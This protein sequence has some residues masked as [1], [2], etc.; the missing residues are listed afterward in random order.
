MSGL[1]RDGL[2]QGGVRGLRRAVVAAETEEILDGRCACAE[3]PVAVPE[4]GNDHGRTLCQTNRVGGHL[5]LECL[6]HMVRTGRG[7]HLVVTS[8]G[9][10]TGTIGGGTVFGDPDLLAGVAVCSED[11]LET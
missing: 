7:G 5:R 9:S 8:G 3:I 1:G 11:T 6:V 2:L 10:E 4:Q